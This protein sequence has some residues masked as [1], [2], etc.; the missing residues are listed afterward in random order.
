VIAFLEKQPAVLR[1]M[2]HVYGLIDQ[3]VENYRSRNFTDLMVAFGCTGGRHRSI[4]CAELL[5]RHLRQK[6]QVTVEIRHLGI[7]TAA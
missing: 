2:N 5:A 6:H 3:S 4:Y 1:F 7:E